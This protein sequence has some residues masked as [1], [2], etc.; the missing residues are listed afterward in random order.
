MPR[1]VLYPDGI[2]RCL[3][4]WQ[5]CS[6]PWAVWDAGPECVELFACARCRGDDAALWRELQLGLP[7]LRV[8]GAL[9]RN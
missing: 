7:R 1:V 2:P 9:W 8:Q 5:V 6:Q 3:G 4:C